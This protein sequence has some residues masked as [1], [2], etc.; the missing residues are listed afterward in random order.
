MHL[1]ERRSLRPGCK[2]GMIEP[3]SSLPAMILLQSPSIAIKR[4]RPRT[5]PP[6][7]ELDVPPCLRADSRLNP[8]CSVSSF[9]SFA[10]QS[11][12]HVDDITAEEAVR[13]MLA[14]YRHVRTP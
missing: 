1:N 10:L 11:Q 13:L 9:R 12:V 8:Q 3:R 7:R 2:A 6:L 14:F 5:L 4:V